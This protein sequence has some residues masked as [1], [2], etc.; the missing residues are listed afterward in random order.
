MRWNRAV[1]FYERAAQQQVIEATIRAATDTKGMGGWI[2]RVPPNVFKT[3]VPLQEIWPQIAAKLEEAGI[4]PEQLQDIDIQDL[5]SI[6]QPNLFHHGDQPVARVVRDGQ[7]EL[8]EFDKDLFAAISGMNFFQLPYFLEITFG[9]AT[10]LVKLGATGLSLAFS[11]RNVIKDYGTDLAQ[12]KHAGDDLRGLVG[13]AEMIKTY[14]Y[15]EAQKLAGNQADPIVQL[16]QEMGGEL[17]QTLGLDRKRVK[18]AVGV[19]PAKLE[20]WVQGQTGGLFRAVVKPSEMVTYGSEFTTADVPGVGGFVFR[21]DFAKSVNE[22]YKKLSRTG[23]E[24]NSAR[25]N[26]SLTADLAE[27][28]RRLREY[29]GWI[30]KIRKQVKDVANR[31]ARFHREKYIV[32]LAR[33]ALG[34]PELKRYPN[35]LPDRTV[36]AEV[37]DVVSGDKQIAAK[38]AVLARQKPYI[39]D[40]VREAREKGV[41]SIDLLHAKR[42]ELEAKKQAAAKWLKERGLQLK[43]IFYSGVL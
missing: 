1:R 11:G 30:S 22:F 43:P 37:R 4:E 27:K 24:Y 41:K 9:G 19:S 42:Q 6:W 21:R 40:V 36:P 33:H 28:Y 39:R 35:P 20:H 17:S 32:G 12:K 15:S 23:Q 3:N 26:G 18:S 25:Q 16:W 34:K 13:P 38:A 29:A 10:R 8:Y 14:I 31:D 2:D 7:S 5:I